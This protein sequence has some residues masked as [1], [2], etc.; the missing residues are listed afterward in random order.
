[1]CTANDP[2]PWVRQGST[3]KNPTVNNL[4]MLLNRIKTVTDI[5]FWYGLVVKQLFFKLYFKCSFNHQEMALFDSIEL[6]TY[7][8]KMESIEKEGF[9]SRGP[10]DVIH[11]IIVNWILDL[12]HS[13]KNMVK[14]VMSKKIYKYYLFYILERSF[15]PTIINLLF[16]IKQS[17]EIKEME[18]E[19]KQ[20]VNEKIESE[21][22]KNE[23]K[24]ENY[25]SKDDINPLEKHCNGLISVRNSL[26]KN[27]NNISNELLIKS[28]QLMEETHKKFQNDLVCFFDL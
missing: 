22:E 17:K 3:S 14:I 12:F 9:G 27:N 8:I 10:P 7:N 28:A 25:E 1:M 6:K 2:I 4:A 18:E 19:K 21:K 26:T 23:L 11:K 20:T 15:T 5:E 13:N 24:N 16:N